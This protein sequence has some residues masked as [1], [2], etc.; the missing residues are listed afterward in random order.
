MANES[1]SVKTDLDSHSDY[2]LQL[3]RWLLKPIGIWPASPCTPRRDKIVSYI[4]NAICYSFMTFFLALCLLYLFLE[5]DSFH[6]KMRMIAAF[7]HWFVSIANYTILL[8]KRKDIRRCFEYIEKDW[9]RAM[10]ERDRDVMLK[11]AKFGRYVATSCVAFMQG[12]V[13]AFCFITALNTET[14]RVGNE[15]R[16]VHPLPVL[17]YKKLIDV[18]KSP[19]NEIML[20]AE[21]FSLF[22]ANSTTVGVFSLSAVLAAHARGQFN[23]LMLRITELVN[24]SEKPKK[25][26]TFNDIGMLVE[27]HLRTLNFVSTTEEVMNRIYFLELLRCVLAIS[28]LGYLILMDWDD[29]EVK[30]LTTYFVVLISICFNMFIM[31]YNGEIIAEQCN[32]VGDVIYM[33]NWYDLPDKMILDLIFVIARSNVVVEITAGKII[34]MSVS[35][36]GQMMKTSFAYLNMFRQMTMR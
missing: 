28:I 34:H 5:D 29:R 26:T 17:V 19:T 31:C 25:T 11:N 36:F 1:V 8:L 16:I 7:S 13:L 21:V 18:N 32:D 24:G 14:I 33:T 6:I 30:K 9:I 10:N 4:V 22:I 2:S 35:T 15:T 20:F 27:H 3:N 23:I 12:G